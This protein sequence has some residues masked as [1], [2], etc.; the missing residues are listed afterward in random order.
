MFKEEG[1]SLKTTP[2]G[3]LA[4]LAALCLVF[5]QLP[6]VMG[7]SAAT[8]GTHRAAVAHHAA[9]SRAGVT[10]RSQGG[11]GAFVFTTSTTNTA[12][13]TPTNGP[14]GAP[15]TVT[16]SI[17]AST[18]VT[19]SIADAGVTTP[20][21]SA[22]SN[23][24]GAFTFNTT[25]PLTLPT[26]AASIQAAVGATQTASATFT[27][28]PATLAASTVFGTSTVSGT[29]CTTVTL[30][31]TNFA[32]GVTI[33]P[34]F[35]YT[36]ANGVT[37]T[38]VLTNVTPISDGSSME[39]DFTTTAEITSTIVPSIP[40]S[41]TDAIS[42]GAS[43]PITPTGV[44]PVP[45]TV[46]LTPTISAVPNTPGTLLG[47]VGPVFTAGM[48]N[49][50]NI[51][52]TGGFLPDS[53][54]S[55][56][57]GLTGTTPISVYP[58]T[59]ATT[60]SN[61]NFTAAI[62]FST[63]APGTYVLV[64]NDLGSCNVATTTITV[65][66]PSLPGPPVSTSYFAEGYT[67]SGAVNGKASFTT[68]FALLNPNVS[69]VIVTNTYLLETINEDVVSPTAGAAPDVVVVT[70]TLS[71][72]Q[73]LVVNAATDIASRPVSSGPDA[74]KTL[75]GTDQKFATIVQT[76]GFQSTVLPGLGGQVRGVAAE[77]L[78]ERSN[79]SG[80]REDGDVSLGT[81]SANTSYYFA[82]GYTKG[83]FQEYL[84]LMNPSATTTATVTIVPVPE[85]SSSGVTTTLPAPFPAITLDAHQRLTL[86]MRRLNAGAP[87]AKIGLIVNSDN[88]IVA[89][90]VQ[91]FGPG[92][93]S[94]RNGEAIA[95]GLT[96]AAK[97]LN[98]AYGSLTDVATGTITATS[99]AAQTADDR[100][101][102]DVMNP[103]IGGQLVA[104]TY[105]NV[106][107]STTP[108][109][110]GQTAHVTI[111]LRD[112][113]GHLIGF[114][115]SDVQ[116]GTRFT[117]TDADLRTGSN[118]VGFPGVPSVGLGTA[119]APTRASV[120]SVIVSS[121]ER[122]V[123]ELAQYFGQGSVTPSGD[124]NAG[125]PGLDLVGAPSGENDVLFPALSTTDPASS[126]PLSNTVFLYNPGVN[127]VR[128][129]GTFYG[130][131]GVVAHQTYTVGPDAIQVIG[132]NITDSGGTGSAHGLPIPAGT[133][134]AEFSVDQLR[135]NFESGE[136]AQAPET[137]VA[138]AVT[139]SADGSQWWGS[140]GLY[141][142]PVAPSCSN[143]N[144]Q[145]LPAGCP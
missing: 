114:F 62:P 130:A 73:D 54:I 4:A 61:G 52:G 41:F 116:P 6:A 2:K 139:H 45:F 80:A 124:A 131:T 69:S 28:N 97:Q 137:F 120:F 34:T 22:T 57:F 74:G 134:G 46:A 104:G 58:T 102:V 132:T 135:G 70:H 143:A 95:A 75:P 90:R 43:Y 115:I 78:I 31:G 21:G 92:D 64:A 5:L 142:L 27:V 118:S 51:S 63:S 50:L 122:V 87:E 40:Y 77:R 37:N 53:P 108:A 79:N 125:A 111:S 68:N 76:A 96:T 14:V 9:A 12:T 145:P 60:D 44:Y 107:G 140:Q 25:L 39:G 82:E 123:S 7:V 106:T 66:T 110:A 85:G 32:P 83:N 29:L 121:S 133:L 20:L 33:A 117:L 101:F 13:L 109:S 100:P 72:L 3:L 144:G 129:N 136:P 98:F 30:N 56:T 128:V 35:V 81:T 113:A 47:P 94:N 112:E 59:A 49:T 119:V 42:A 67:G 8:A 16:G 126:L 99:D 138:A 71:A 89:E 23:G 26:G 11:S 93:G 38:V 19:F 105:S 36:T 15:I 127:T 48:T 55:F 103:N 65:V 141:P 17:S 24:S 91:Y 10:P 86:N 1:M 18:P 84:L 88:P